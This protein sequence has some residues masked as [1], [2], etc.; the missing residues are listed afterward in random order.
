LWEY[1][2][3]KDEEMGYDEK[4]NCRQPQ[5]DDLT[6]SPPPKPAKLR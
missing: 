1:I 4:G 3:A 6:T 5:E 2:L